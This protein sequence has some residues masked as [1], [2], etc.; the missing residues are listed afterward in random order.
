MILKAFFNPL[1]SI[2][3]RKSLWISQNNLKTRLKC[4]FFSYE[5]MLAFY[6]NKKREK[7]QGKCLTYLKEQT[8]SKCHR[9]VYIK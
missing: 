6:T 4:I 1:I 3:Y 8:I 5:A 2:K 7:L 9:I